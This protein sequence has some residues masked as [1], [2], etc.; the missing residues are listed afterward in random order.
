VSVT[1][2]WLRLCTP[3]AASPGLIPGR[4]TRSHM[5]QPRDHVLQL[6]TPHAATKDATRH[7]EDPACG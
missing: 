2:L 5:P 7:K 3:N 6:K 4:R 1:S